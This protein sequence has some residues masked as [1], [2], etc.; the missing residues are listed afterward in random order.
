MTLP[1]PPIADAGRRPI[2]FVTAAVW[3]ISA[4]L[5]LDVTV[6]ITESVRP[7]AL[8]DLVSLTGCHLLSYSLMVFLMLRLYEPEADVLQVLAV[9]RAPLLAFPLAAAIGAGLYPILSVVDDIA[10]RRF[11]PTAEEQELIGKLMSASTVSKRVALVMALVIV[12]PTAEEF[13]FRGV[14]FGGLRRARPA[15]HAILASAVYFAAVR[16]G[17]RAFGSMIALGL[18]LAWLRSRAGSVLVSLTAHVA[19][20]AVP[21][22]P[23]LAGADPMADDQYSHSLVLGGIGLAALA[24]GMMT[25]LAGRDTKMITARAEDA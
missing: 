2:S 3:V 25:W 18:A 16:G 19:F 24:A 11:P 6:A 9:R 17:G 21:V 13:F 1:T 12:M 4:V 14:L 20:F 23:L 22:L 10:A 5:V 7:G 8:E 15:L